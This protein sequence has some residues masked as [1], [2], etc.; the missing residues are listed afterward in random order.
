MF[1]VSQIRENFTLLL[2][3][4]CDKTSDRGHQSSNI[5]VRMSSNV[6][7]FKHSNVRCS[8]VIEYI[9]VRSFAEHERT[10]DNRSMAPDNGDHNL[11][12]LKVWTFLG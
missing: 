3:F 5:H 6:R 2:R 10:L 1:S 9:G 4:T 11:K 12:S 7:F 8:N